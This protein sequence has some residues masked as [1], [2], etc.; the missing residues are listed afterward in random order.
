M[1]IIINDQVKVIAGKDKGKTGK[2][3]KAYPK[4]NRVIVQGINK[5][6]RHLK[7]QDAKNAGGIVEVERALPVESVMLIC[8]SCKK[9]ARIRMGTTKTG[10]K[11]RMCQKCG[12]QITL[13]KV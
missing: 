12:Q 2:V 6:K 1:K 3:T 10:E 7:K 13:K 8:T 5:F 11:Y 9:P 4:E